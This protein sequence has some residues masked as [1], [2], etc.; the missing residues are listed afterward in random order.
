VVVTEAS[1]QGDLLRVVTPS[2][3]QPLPRFGVILG[4]PRSG[5]TWLQRILAA[6]PAV[7]TPQETHL[8]DLYLAPLY[9]RWWKQ[10]S[11]LERNL[12]DLSSGRVVAD[13]IFGLPTIVEDSDIDAAARLLLDGMIRRCA[14]AVDP[15]GD[16]VEMVIEKTP[17]NALHVD[18]LHR[19]APECRYVHVIRDPRDVAASLIAAS[20]EWGAMWAPRTADAAARMWNSHV[21]KARAARQFGDR[22]LEVRYEDLRAD[23]VTQVERVL[24]F[25]DLA[26]DD[27]AQLARREGE[28]AFT[29]QLRA[30]LGDT[31]YEPPTFSGGGAVRHRLSPLQ[32]L[33]VERQTAVLREELGYAATERWPQPSAFYRAG[34]PAAQVVAAGRRSVRTAMLRGIS[35]RA[36]SAS[37]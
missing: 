4:A 29:P 6:H 2:Q 32:Q 10:R 35:G 36:V 8:L 7:A 9:S 37:R 24:D 12:E 13:R 11:R 15:S 14:S 3:P 26:T 18:V 22:Y 17:S 34:L 28:Y 5:T 25:L 20:Q 30:R 1:V 23:T 33:V 31:T 16:R 19:I 21:E 27:V